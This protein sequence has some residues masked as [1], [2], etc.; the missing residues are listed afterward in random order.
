MRYLR[1]FSR[2]FLRGYVK[3]LRQAAAVLGWLTVAY[4]AYLMWEL[5][6]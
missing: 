6:K 1:I 5:S 3:G 2:A 4:F